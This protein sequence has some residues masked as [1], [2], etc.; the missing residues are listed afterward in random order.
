MALLVHPGDEELAWFAGPV[1]NRGILRLTALP[2]DSLHP[3]FRLLTV[4]TA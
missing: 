2:I 1:D 4:Q 3:T